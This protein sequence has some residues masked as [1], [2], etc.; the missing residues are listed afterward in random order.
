MTDITH[1]KREL[2]CHYSIL[3]LAEDEHYAANRGVFV[4]SREPIPF[5][6]REKE[7][8]D[9]LVQNMDSKEIA[10]ILCIS[11][12]TVRSHRKHILNK[13][14]CKNTLCLIMKSFE[15]GWI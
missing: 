7:I 9:H 8:F 4:K 3:T 15:N 5:S 6:R 10:S 2:S 12:E 1:L 11:E 14:G 13:S